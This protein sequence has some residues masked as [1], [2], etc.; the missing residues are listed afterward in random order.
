MI[1]M[2]RP[3]VALTAAL[4]LLLPATA[5]A[6][7]LSGDARGLV[8]ALGLQTATVGA[9]AI[10][11]ETGQILIDLDGETALIPASNQKLLATGVALR[12]LGCDHELITEFLLDGD[13]VTVVGGGDPAFGDAG[14]LEK[15]DPPVT[16]ESVLQTLASAVA[17][18]AEGP[19]N[20]LIIDPRIFDTQRVHP[21]WP[22]DQ[23]NA[24]YCAEVAGLNFH[25]N[26][27]RVFPTPAAAAGESPTAR[28]QPAAPWVDMRIRAR[29]VSD[30]RNTAWVARSLTDNVFTLMGD[31][32]T[33]VEIDVSV[34]DPAWVFGRIF[35]D[36]LAAAGADLPIIPRDELIHVARQGEPEP[37]GRVVA[38]VVTPL[39]DVVNRT[40]GVSYNLYAEALVKLVGNRV[41]GEAG[42][43]DNGASVMRMELADA[44]LPSRAASTRIADGSG[45]SRD[46]RVSAL[47]LCDWLSALASD[48]EA[49]PC[50]VASLP[51]AGEGTLRRRFGD[52]ELD[53]E[54]RGKSGTLNG[55]RCLSGYVTDT[56]T[57]RRVAYSILVNDLKPGRESRDA[58]VLHERMVDLL[59]NW[60]TETSEL[61]AAV[62]G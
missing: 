43:W 53:H 7:E 56:H 3:L 15:L 28:L 62:G 32:R 23:L 52:I 30:G 13:T 57:G 2:Y 25:A 45:M 61:P 21:S 9:A 42:S 38:R 36:R 31:V 58:R 50:F 17:E 27:L 47:T 59:D 20:R 1:K 24:W 14:L 60:L 18:S 41:T 46:N 34:T 12:I 10:D 37:S 26:V 54:V 22:V 5:H 44:L 4:L 51:E 8:E 19:I 11:L 49:G 39:V 55:V 29:T 6:G 16:V 48:P 40:N 33:P 35:I